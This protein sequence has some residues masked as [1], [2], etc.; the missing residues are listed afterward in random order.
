[1]RSLALTIILIA[2]V[3]L[4]SHAVIPASA[5]LGTFT[6]A[7]SASGTT[8]FV[9]TSNT[10]STNSTTNAGTT[11]TSANGTLTT[12]ASATSNTTKLTTTTATTLQ[13]TTSSGTTT[14]QT[15]GP[16]TQASSAV[17]CCQYA[18]ILSDI[19]AH[20]GE[21]IQIIG[22][23][24]D[25]YGAAEAGVQ[26]QYHDS[27]NSLNVV[28]E[29]KGVFRISFTIPEFPDSNIAYYTI[30]MTD[31]STNWGATANGSYSMNTAGASGSAPVIYYSQ[32]LGGRGSY[33]KLTSPTMPAVI[34]V[35]GGYELDSL[36]GD[37]QL[38]DATT[39]FLDYLA[40]AG[41]NV[42]A[43]VGWF[44][45]DVPS[46]PLVLGALLKYGFLM[47]QVYVIGWSAGGV[48]SAWAITHDYHRI[49][50]LG[51]IMDAELTGPT[52][53]GTRTDFSVFT[54]ALISNQAA[55][56]HLLV[57]GE[58]DSGTISIQTVG[59]W[60]KNSQPGLARVDPLPYSHTWIGTTVEPLVRQDIVSFFKSGNIG[61]FAVIPINS[62]QTPT[63]VQITTNIAI[64]NMNYSPSSML[65][66][67]NVTGLSTQIGVVNLFIPK[68]LLDG[69]PVVT[70]G[71]NT[72]APST[73]EDPEGYYV[74]FT[75]TTTPD[76]ILV[77]GQNS[78]PEFPS[79]PIILATMI[80][81]AFISA[82]ITRKGM[83]P[84]EI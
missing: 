51:V 24:G 71:G 83:K 52:E 36:H 18:F 21:V 22:F 40:T 49:L 78:L 4:S 42:V 37:S 23:V 9:S 74:F 27:M 58:D 80:M 14:L 25:R 7:M 35:G 28:S 12:T 20:P 72:F 2:G 61:N 19:N 17:N 67:M 64:G 70:I 26:V 32:G 84:T 73:Y 55:I 56:P 29:P 41:F 16:P 63:T 59:Q 33:L 66:K 10:T 62:A 3:L 53:T 5:G 57:W 13:L 1:M 81:F 50:N 69:E 82:A 43:P 45:P 39:G 38:D 68:N 60:V 15:S 48:A 75:F 65:L 8:P 46:F 31:P 76:S 6:P 34:F 79:I 11:N 47:S 54:T 30:D 44:V 77:G